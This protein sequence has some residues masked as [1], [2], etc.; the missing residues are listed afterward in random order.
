M[1]TAHAVAA[2]AKGKR[3]K[4]HEDH[5]EHENHERWL[6]TYADMITLLMVLFIVLFAIGQTDLAKFRQLRDGLERTF[7]TDSS[8]VLDS[9][10]GIMVDSSGV[11]PI[12]IEEAGAA[13]EA[14]EEARRA[15]AEDQAA[16]ERT[17][18]LLGDRLDA[19]GVG[20]DVRLDVERRGLIVTIV[21][22]DVLF[23]A[24]S[25][26]VRPDGAAILS[27]VAG[28]IADLPNPVTVEGHTD[29]R[30]ITSSRFPSNWEL[31]TSRATSV[32]RLLLTSAALDP[33]RLSAAGYADTHPIATNDTPE[34]RATNRRVEIVV[35]SLVDGAELVEDV[36]GT[37]DGPDPLVAIGDP[38]PEVD[39]G[40]EEG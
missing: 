34:G 18:E 2:H 26:A 25:D 37:E 30:P 20:G 5:E 7:G 36:A 16:L 12:A 32:L 10:A 38:I 28:S 17:A 13:L 3:H 4:K 1:S 8:G 39:H 9:G 14:R 15:L 23:D 21:T 35:H 29:D 31:S 11:A 33:A 27:T 6:I 40:Q 19:A 24:G 22:D